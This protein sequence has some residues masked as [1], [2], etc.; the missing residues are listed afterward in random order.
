MYARG[1]KEFGKLREYVDV[2]RLVT[3]ETHVRTAKPNALAC[4]PFTAATLRIH[5]DNTQ[6]ISSPYSCNHLIASNTMA[7]KREPLP[8]GSPASSIMPPSPPPPTQHVQLYNPDPDRA[9]PQ[10]VIPPSMLINPLTGVE[11]L[12]FDEAILMYQAADVFYTKLGLMR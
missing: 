7:P 11:V 9:P 8:Y 6:T 4:L 2:Y 10:P 12:H 5:T 3:I 1:M